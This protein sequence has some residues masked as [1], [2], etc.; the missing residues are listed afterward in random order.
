MKKYFA[1]EWDEKEFPYGI[2][3]SDLN[4]Y[5]SRFLNSRC[6]T[7]RFTVIEIQLHCGH[8]TSAIVSADDGLGCGCTC[9][10]SMCGKEAESNEP[11]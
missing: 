4:L 11:N 5:I 2:K 7:D 1:I 9:S 10:C 6:W 8:P 3:H